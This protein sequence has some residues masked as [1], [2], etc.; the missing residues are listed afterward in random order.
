MSEKTKGKIYRAGTLTYTLGGVVV[1]F[2]WLLWGDFAWSMKDRGIGSAATIIVKQIGISDLWYSLFIVAYPSFTNIF[3]MPI[4]SYKSDRYRSR[5]GRRIPFL[6]FTTPFV[7]LGI[8]GV[9]LSTVLGRYLHE[10][11][12]ALSLHA[13]SLAVFAVAWISLDFGAT[14]SGAIAGALYNDVVPKELIGRFYACFRAISLGAGIIFNYF[15]VGKVEQYAVWICLG[16]GLLYGIGLFSLCLKVKEGEYPPPPAEEKKQGGMEHFFSSVKIYFKECFSQ[17]YYLWVFF[18]FIIGS[19]S[20]SPVNIYTVFYC[21]EV[22]LSMEGMGEVI[23]LTYVISF[24]LCYFLGNLADRFH[25][26]RMM[27]LSLALYG[28]VMVFGCVYAVDKTTWAV[29]LLV[30]GVLSG[31]FFTLSA[32]YPMRLLPRERFATLNSACS[33]LWAIV[34]VVSAPIYGGILE[35]LSRYHVKVH[36]RYTFLMGGVLAALGIAVLLVVYRG[37]KRY[38]GDANYQAPEV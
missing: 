12:P 18:G 32:S 3:L 16:L 7:V 6:F 20:A 4:I 5:W 19:I 31:V 26:I 11:V 1:L 29:F 13:A 25:P 36:Y 17:P 22:G 33:M 14:M 9:G 21:Q 15:L 10:L 24:S 27:I 2:F 35:I 23:A 34:N 30:H 28:A 8:I 38:G 37:F